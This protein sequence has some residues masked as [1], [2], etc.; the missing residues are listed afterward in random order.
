MVGQ[1]AE[2]PSR[3]AEAAK[4]VET[5]TGALGR[6]RNPSAARDAVAV[7]AQAPWGGRIAIARRYDCAAAERY[8]WPRLR[9]GN[10]FA[11]FKQYRAPTYLDNCVARVGRKYVIVQS[12]PSQVKENLNDG[13]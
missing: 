12:R 9:R 3:L 2:R 7:H 13:Q 6:G 10:R 4:L 1:P 5:Y 8:P 11:C